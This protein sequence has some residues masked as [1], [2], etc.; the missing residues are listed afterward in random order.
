MAGH[1][2]SLKGAAVTLGLNKIFDYA[3][4]VE[5]ETR[6]N[7]RDG[8]MEL[9]NTPDA[10]FIDLIMLHISGEKLCQIIRSRPRFKDIN[11]IILILSAIMVPHILLALE[12]SNQEPSALIP[13]QTIGL[14]DVFPRHITTELL[15]I[16]RPFES[17]SEGDPYAP[18]IIFD[19]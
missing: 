17:D 2:H 11:I 12:K 4:K 13:G 14:E 8:M 9:A 16:K 3:N 18:L 7:H 5:T 19:F 6:I 1:A 15:S 10:I